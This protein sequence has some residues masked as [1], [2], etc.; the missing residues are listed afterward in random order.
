MI[1]LLLLLGLLLFRRGVDCVD[2]L[3]VVKVVEE[4]VGEEVGGGRFIL[5]AVS[6][7]GG[8][9]CRSNEGSFGR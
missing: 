6:G 5:L 3:F 9:A 2:R 1:L 4:E 8:Y 7:A